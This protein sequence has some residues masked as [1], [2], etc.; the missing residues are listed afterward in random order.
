MMVTFGN[1]SGRVPPVDLGK[2]KGA[3][4][5]TRPRC[6]TRQTG[7]HTSTSSARNLKIEIRQHVLETR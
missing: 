1:A 3:L 6:Q 5:L 7:M 4:F 2:L